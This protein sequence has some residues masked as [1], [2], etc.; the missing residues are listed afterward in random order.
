MVSPPEEGGLKE[1]RDSVNNIIISDSMLHNIF[2][3]QLKKIFH[4]IKLCVVV[5]VSYLPK[6]CI[7]IYYHVAIVN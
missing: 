7:H 2:P 4:E 1:A 5:S 6:V 3:P